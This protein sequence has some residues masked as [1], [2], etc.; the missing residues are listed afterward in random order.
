M[1]RKRGSKTEERGRQRERTRQSE[2][3]R[4]RMRECDRAG[5]K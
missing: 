5:E 4:E 1:E 3:R 2:T